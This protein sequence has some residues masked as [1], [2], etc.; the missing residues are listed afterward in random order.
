MPAGAP[1]RKR[2]N[3]FDADI[4]ALTRIRTA[5]KIDNRLPPELVAKAIKPLDEL[6]DALGL[7]HQTVVARKSAVRRK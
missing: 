3:G 4:S 2:D 1:V 5:L 6:V 7:L